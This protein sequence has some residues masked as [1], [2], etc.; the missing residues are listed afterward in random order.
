MAHADHGLQQIIRFALVT[1]LRKGDLRALTKANYRPVTH[2]LEGVQSKTGLP[3]KVGIPKDLE[4]IILT[5]KGVSILN[6]TDFSRRWRQLIKKTNMPGLQMRDLRRSA[7]SWALKKSKDMALIS[8]TLGHQSIEMTQRYLGTISESRQD[9]A[10]TLGDLFST[11]EKVERVTGI[12]PVSRPWEGQILPLNHTRENWDETLTPDKTVTQLYP[13]DQIL[14]SEKSQERS[15]FSPEIL[16]KEIERRQL[17]GKH[18]F[19]H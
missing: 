5:S 8:A 16:Q 15:E 11:Q 17:L 13:K 18:A 7:A 6:F 14:D 9:I 3:F 4:Q 2:T 10:N 19:Y 1:M 12:E